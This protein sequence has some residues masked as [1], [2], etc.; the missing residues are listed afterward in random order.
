MRDGEVGFSRIHGILLIVLFLLLRL[1]ILTADPPGRIIT[2]FQDVAF[3]LFDEGW[4]TANAR[5][6]ALF[7]ETRGTGFDLFW[8]SPVFTAVETVAFRIGGVSLASARLTSVLFGAAGILLM[9][10]AG[11]LGARGVHG[12]RCAGVAALLWT[13][14]FAGAHYGRLALPETT[15]TA[16]G[17]AGSVA[18]LLGTRAGRFGA[19]AF[20]ALAMLTKPHFGFLLPTFLVAGWVLAL[21]HG[22]PRL[23]SV[24]WIFAGAAIPLAAWGAYFAMHVQE[25]LELLRFYAS[26][27]W[28]ADLP[29]DVGAGIALI[30]PAV[31]VLVAGVVYR[32]PLFLNLPV[33][34]LGAAA[35]APGVWRGVLFPRRAGDVPDAGIVFGL[36]ALVG[37]VLISIIPFQPFRYYIP[38]LP[39]LAYL[40]GWFLARGAGAVTEAAGEVGTASGAG[41]AGGDAAGEAGAAGPRFAS[42]VLSVARWTLGALVVGQITF[43]ILHILGTDALT[44]RSNLPPREMLSPIDFHFTPFLLAVARSRSLAP[45]GELAPEIAYVAALALL[46]TVALG[47][48]AVVAV[49]AVRRFGRGFLPSTLGPRSAR[50]VLAALV[51]Y[52]AILWG[53]WLPRRAYTLPEMGR[54]LDARI[55]PGGTVSPAGVYSLESRLRFDSS[56]VRE[57][58]KFDATGATSHFVLMGGHPRIGVLPEGKIERM[59]PGARRVATYHLT[60]DYV[61]HLYAAP[62]RPRDADGQ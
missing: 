62:A 44:A 37:G 22:R 17:L 57:G 51:I 56:A 19:G 9:L 47:V 41:V 60:G 58:R 21:R 16:L 28:Y 45:F 1:P 13:I 29:S 23:A 18:L 55:P 52:Q 46:A 2:H 38:L 8:V 33:V 11:R 59:H 50:I 40:A 4:W 15:G 14:L 27:R 20:A 24:G 12:P 34:F 49:V 43:A 7:G 53:T 42:G 5:E 25:A 48:A 39:A 35:A 30:K 10:A 31:Q 61:C 6:K 32:H 36:W 54:D 3:S 26:D